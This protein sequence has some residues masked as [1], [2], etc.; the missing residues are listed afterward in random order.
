M[1]VEDAWFLYV[2]VYGHLPE[3]R[4][5]ML[6]SVEMALDNPREYLGPRHLTHL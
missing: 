3:D 1:E 2:P 4:E 6:A 5:K